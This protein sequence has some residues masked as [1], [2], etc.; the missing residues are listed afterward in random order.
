MKRIVCL[1]GFLLSAYTIIAQ[2]EGVIQKRERIDR[3]KS[4]FLGFGPSITL[5]ENI[6]DYSIGFNF[7]AGFVKRLNRLLSIG[8][9]ISYLR[10]NYDPEQTQSE[11][12]GNSDISIDW[13]SQYDTW[14]E[15]YP[16]TEGNTYDYRYLLSLEGGDV[17]LISLALN[18]KLNFIPITDNTKFSVYG[19]AKPFISIANREAVTGSGV[20]QVWES[21][22]DR[23]GTLTNESDDVLYYYQNDDTWHPDGYVED[24]DSEGPDGYPVLAKES[25]VTGGIF[26][27]PGIE[28]VPANAVSF[29]FQAAFGYTFPVSFVSTESYENTVTSYVDEEFPIV[30]EGF[31]SVNLQ[32][33]VSFNF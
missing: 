17:S 20:R 10:F 27:G 28:F 11:Y 18:I 31:P 4:V 33:G 19:F 22:E 7:E 16:I 5:G 25:S 3:S 1:A 26:L 29:Y 32:F 15:K 12:K 30:K 24:W 14:S 9:S 23:N 6:G 13:Y 2:D 21:Y 8:P